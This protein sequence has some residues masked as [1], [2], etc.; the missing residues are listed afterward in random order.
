LTLWFY[1]S[2]RLVNNGFWKLLTLTLPTYC[3]WLAGWDPTLP[4]LTLVDVTVLLVNYGCTAC[5]SVGLVIVIARYCSWRMLDSRLLR[6][7]VVIACADLAAPSDV[8]LY[9]TGCLLGIDCIP[10]ACRLLL[11]LIVGCNLDQVGSLTLLCT[12]AG[13]LDCTDPWPHCTCLV[14]LDCVAPTPTPRYIA[15]AAIW[16]CLVVIVGQ[17][18]PYLTAILLCVQ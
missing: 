13:L 5:S 7:P 4:W 1:G 8:T 16:L 6:Y 2:Q 11:L 12:A 10:L 15:C 3:Y 9:C 18:G 14:T 17:P